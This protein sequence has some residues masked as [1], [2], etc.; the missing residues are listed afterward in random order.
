MAGRLQIEMAFAAAGRGLVVTGE[1]VEGQVRIGGQARLPRLGGGTGLHRVA[2]V[3]LMHDFHLPAIHTA[4]GLVFADVT[5]SEEAYLIQ[6]LFA[7]Q[8]VAVE[9]PEAPAPAPAPAWARP[10]RTRSTV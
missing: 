10:G 4:V 2:G 5:E 8:T 6:H 7:G 1:V 3:E 9:D